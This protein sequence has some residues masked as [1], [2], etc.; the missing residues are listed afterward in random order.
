MDA[1]VETMAAL[2]VVLFW[3]FI[4]LLI[5]LSVAHFVRGPEE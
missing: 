3:I 1:L 4:C 2:G 5:V